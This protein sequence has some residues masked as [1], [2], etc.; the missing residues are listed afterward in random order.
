[1]NKLEKT[2]RQ[3]LDLLLVEKNLVESQE[4]AQ[5]LILAG[6]VFVNG[7]KATKAGTLFKQAEITIK[8]TIPFVGKGGIK[9]DAAIN[10]FGIEIKGKTSLDIGSST[11]GFIDCLLKRGVKKA[12]GIDVGKK[13]LHYSLQK[14][15]KVIN[16]EGINAK[17]PFFLP[18]A[19][20]IITIDVSFISIMKVLIPSSFHLKAGGFLICLIKPQFEAEKNEITQ[21]GTPKNNKIIKKS[22]E[23]VA[24]WLLQNKFSLIKTMSAP[25]TG[26]AKNQEFF[27]LIQKNF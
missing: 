5:S 19:V 2:K 6:L 8:K 1:M 4:K 26:S 17:N 13:Q 12:F 21:K 11:G 3:R 9:L 24:N 25:I 7:Q 27:F 23:K 14:N 22:L 15:P 20:D 18:E 10:E 16:F